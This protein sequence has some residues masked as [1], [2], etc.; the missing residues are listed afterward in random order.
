MF[1]ARDLLLN[2]GSINDN[3]INVKKCARHNGLK[4]K[5]TKKARSMCLNRA[6]QDCGRRLNQSHLRSMAEISFAR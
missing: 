4:L 6:V 1:V 2:V 5:S 3:G